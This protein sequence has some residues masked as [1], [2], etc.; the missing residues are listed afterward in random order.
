MIV[1][2]RYSVCHSFCKQ[3][4]YHIPQAYLPPVSQRCC[5]PLLPL[6]MSPADVTS[7]PLLL[8]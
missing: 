1:Q 8:T 2:A 6:I 4:P 3:I 5:P 7:R